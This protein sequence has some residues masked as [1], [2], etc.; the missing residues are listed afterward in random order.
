MSMDI[1]KKWNFSELKIRNLFSASEGYGV[2]DEAPPQAVFLGFQL[3]EIF[4][5]LQGHS[6]S[7]Q[8]SNTLSSANQNQQSLGKELSVT[9]C[10]LSWHRKFLI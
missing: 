10:S 6:E 7:T 1:M 3:I 8:S 5:L 2:R 4:H 9:K